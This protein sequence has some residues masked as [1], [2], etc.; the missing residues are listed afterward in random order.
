MDILKKL[1]NQLQAYRPELVKNNGSFLATCRVAR[2][3][4]PRDGAEFHTVLI[5]SGDAEGYAHAGEESNCV[6]VIGGEDRSRF[7]QSAASVVF[8]P[9]DTDPDALCGAVSQLLSDAAVYAR[10]RQRLSDAYFDR[11]DVKRLVV[12]AEELLDAPIGVFDIAS[13]PVALGERFKRLNGDAAFREYQDK[14]YISFRFAE[15]NMYRDF[16]HVLESAS[17]PFTF[18]YS[19][20]H[21]LTRRVHKIYLNGAYVAH[22]SM[23]LRDDVDIPEVKDE[24]LA[25]L[26]QLIRLELE[27]LSYNPYKLR[28]DGVLL[29]ELLD[30]AYP[31]EQAFEAR[32]ELYGWKL[33]RNFHVINVPRRITFNG[34]QNR[35]QLMPAI[36]IQELIF[37]MPSKV[38]AVRHLVQSERIL[39]LVDM[40]QPCTAEE[41]SR[42][43]D[44]F[45]RD[46]GMTCALSNRFENILDFGKQVQHTELLIQAAL[47]SGDASGLL[48]SGNRFFQSLVYALRELSPRQLCPPELLALWDQGS[49]GQ[50]LM[51]TAHTYLEAG[52]SVKEAAAQLFIHRNTLLRRLTRF[53]E[54]TG[55]DLTRGE[56]AFKVFFSYRFI[57]R[58]DMPGEQGV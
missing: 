35:P 12:L 39:M 37:R 32:A 2:G 58:P 26:C 45:F 43:M 41:F 53:Q 57:T 50:E 52:G 49:T 15:K 1:E 46:G 36:L 48:H 3:E 18:R 56:D 54:Q 34:G 17:K 5:T 19:S 38:H 6:A 40:K 24:V 31:T 8:F 28:P 14:G 16:L 13:T 30:G 44:G 47:C 20:K 29:Q 27:R 23:I 51:R 11:A 33:K 4:A 7:A 42:G 10:A 9:A 21:M 22:C 55:L 25:F